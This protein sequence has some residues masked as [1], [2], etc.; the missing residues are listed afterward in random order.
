MEG[1]QILPGSQPLLFGAVVGALDMGRKNEGVGALDLRSQNSADPELIGLRLGR[2]IW[3][4]ELEG[5]TLIPEQAH[6]NCVRKGRIHILEIFAGSARFSQCCAD[7]FSAR[8]PGSEEIAVLK[9][10]DH[11]HILRRFGFPLSCKCAG[12][13]LVANLRFVCGF[14]LLFFGGVGCGEKYG[15]RLFLVFLLF[16]VWGGG[17]GGGEELSCGKW[18]LKQWQPGGFFW[19]P[20]KQWQMGDLLVVSL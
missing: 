20:P 4:F 12:G 2:M 7:K 10:L 16:F 18:P 3:R 9:A 6:R 19:L 11:P 17:V 13:F 5:H 14:S 8:V 15:F 1:S